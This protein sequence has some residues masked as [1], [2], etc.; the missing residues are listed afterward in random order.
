MS[1][2]TGSNI[3]TMDVESLAKQISEADCTVIDKG[4]PIRTIPSVMPCGPPGVV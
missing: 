1:D 2:E 3:P 4:L